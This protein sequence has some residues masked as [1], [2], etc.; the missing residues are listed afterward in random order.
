MKRQKEGSSP[1]R[2]DFFK[3]AGLG[4]G[5]VAAAGVTATAGKA[6]EVEVARS[7]TSSVYRE[8]SY[9][10]KYYELARF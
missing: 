3:F 10:K 4:A 2:R 5:A 9:V 6:S 8:T 1:S 7:H